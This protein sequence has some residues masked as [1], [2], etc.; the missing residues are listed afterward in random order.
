MKRH[1]FSL[2]FL[3]IS[4]LSYAQ[5]DF[6]KESLVVSSAPSYLVVKVK[7]PSYEGEAVVISNDFYSYYNKKVRGLNGKRFY[8]PVYRD[9]KRRK[10]F[11]IADEDFEIKYD[12]PQPYYFEKIILNYNVL[13]ISKNG[14][15]FFI[16]TYFDDKGDFNPPSSYNPDDFYTIVKVMFD[17]G[18]KTGIGSE[19]SNYE[20]QDSRFYYKENEDETVKFVIPSAYID[21]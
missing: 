21:R 5:Y 10:C 1:I 6:L 9:I 18:I 15:E 12:Q 4:I 11:I 3:L 19:W 13:D 14:I 7:S 16:R 2:L 20:I 8:K 17:A